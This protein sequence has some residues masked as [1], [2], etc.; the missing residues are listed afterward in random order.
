MN[1]T[2]KISARQVCIML[3]PEILGV[4]FVVVPKLA[5]TL[6]W[7]DGLTAIAVATVIAALFAGFVIF[8]VN[9]YAGRDYFDA[10]ES[11]FGKLTADI[12]RCGFIIKTVIFMGFCLRIFA[13]TVADTT[14][15]STSIF[16]V[17]SAMALCALY[18]SLK[19]REVR[20]RLSEILLV[21]MLIVLIIVFACGVKDGCVDEAM[22]ILGERGSDITKA[23]FAVLLWFYPV[24][25]TLLTLPYIREKRNIGRA[26]G[27]SVLVAG[28]IMAI[29]F[30][31]V[32]MR[33]G[34]A[35]MHSLDYPVLEMMYSVNLP[36]SFIERQEGLML[37]VWIVGVFFVICAGIHHSGMCA[38]ELFKG[39]SRGLVS[40]VC[41]V[42]TVIAGL[43]PGSVQRAYNG[44]LDIVMLA[45]SIYFIVVP[46]MLWLALVIKVGRKE[47]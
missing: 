45:E 30:A 39:T 41:T 21:P 36:S 13:H 24:E 40:A 43:I 19:G 23:I 27:I 8:A 9:G 46:V 42:A 26:C 5:I 33:F 17:M 28:G 32:I 47:K 6:A 1:D 37:G 15:G 4:G 25:Y 29:I 20:G 10:C 44:M 22:P 12:L 18:S 7:R 2:D 34:A 35:Q 38:Q 14:E 31:V 11:A 3:I 16:A